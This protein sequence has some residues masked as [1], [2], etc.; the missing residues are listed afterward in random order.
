M[1]YLDLID[2]RQVILDRVFRGDDL[3]VG[4]IQ[5]VEGRVKRRR[6]AG[7]GWAS[8][9]EHAVR[10]LDNVLE[11][12]V[13]VFAE[14]KLTDVHLNAGPV[15]D[16]HDDGLAVTRRHDADTHVEVLPLGRHFDTAVL[17][18]AFLGD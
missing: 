5:L 14:T 16:T 6:F 8:N 3:S 11:A 7:T 12:L 15:E 4:P 9:E 10:A 17:G 13:V 1:L 2:S 18:A